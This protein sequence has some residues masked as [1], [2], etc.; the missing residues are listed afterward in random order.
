MSDLRPRGDRNKTPGIARHG[1]LSRS[2][3]WLTVLKFV[4]GAMAVLLISGASVAAITV[5]QLS[6]NI[7]KVTIVGD[8]EG[9]PPDIASFEGGYNIYIAG[10]DQCENRKGCV[11]RAGKRNDVNIILHVSGDHKS[12]VAVSIP[13]DTVVPIP[14]CQ[15]E[16][17]SGS[18]AAMSAQPINVA[19]YYGGLPCA[20]LTVQALTGLK[21]QFAG[22]ITFKGVIQMSTAVGGV[23]VCIAGPIND[24]NVGLHLK[25]A[26][27]YKL[28]GARALAFLRSRHGVGDGSDLGRI[29][30]QQVYMS[31]LVRKLKSADTLNDISKLYGIA[32][33]ATK[34][35]TLSQNF[36]HPDTMIAIARSLANVPLDQVLFVQYPGTTGGT[37]VYAGKVQ[38][39]VAQA[40]ALF[41][42]LKADKPFSLAKGNTGRGSV[43]STAPPTKKPTATGTATAT[44][45][46]T[47]TKST[48]KAPVL[49]G[50]LGQSAADYTCSK[51]F[52][53]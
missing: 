12:A 16:D 35:M 47:P 32:V 41:A 5:A 37:G 17:G 20:V 11:D 22:L 29:S 1:R 26:G 14:S 10:S 24:E 23:P 6:S 40:D 52:S 44:P 25:K 51:P 2:K 50:V 15:S 28:E 18:N 9:P 31:A 30:S 33:A 49:E 8:T 43:V 27:T 48:T 46:P 19:L 53:E 38:P 3:A 7:K 45:T 21:I 34:N 4:A 42:K 39:I 13:R 36:A